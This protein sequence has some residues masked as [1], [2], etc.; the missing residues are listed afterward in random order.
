MSRKGSVSTIVFVIALLAVVGLG[1]W[2]FGYHQN[3]NS[4]GGAVA[5]TQEAMQCPDGSYVS[6]TGPNC[7]FTA[8][9]SVGTSSTVG[10]GWLVYADSEFGF[11]FAYPSTWQKSNGILSIASPRIVFGNPL[12]GTTTYDMSVSVQDNPQNLSAADFVAQMLTD[13][14][15]QDV[16]NSAQGPAPRLSPQ[17]S[18]QYAVTMGGQP[19]YE[20]YDVFEFDH[21]GERI[22]V[23]QNK[24][25]IVFDFPTAT[26][27]PNIAD[28][29]GN[30]ATAHQITNTLKLDPAIWKFCGG[31]AAGRFP[32]DAGYSCKLDGNYPDAG[33]HCV[34]N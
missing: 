25:M 29:A 26:A 16:A 13:L 28:A 18:K 5:C 3:N 10:T 21:Q 6:R 33:G 15:A 9:P 4:A 32:C 17:F 7:S 20:L 34:K 8:C 1:V 12:N 14:T 19:G 2:Y 30:N 31:I 24:K 22:Y 27:N 23:Q 11:S